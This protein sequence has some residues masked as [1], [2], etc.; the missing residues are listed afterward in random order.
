MNI[1]FKDKDIEE[2]CNTD[3]VARKQLGAIC[4]KKLRQRLDMLR[5]AANLDTLRSLP[6]RCHEL[7]G[8]RK[9]QLSLDLEHPLRLIF[10]CIGEE[11]YKEDTGLDWKLVT[12]VKILG[13]EDTHE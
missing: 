2:L 9:G 3:K 8:D 12:T 4:A 1:Q 5:A 7:K 11:I 6:G 13:M 10:E